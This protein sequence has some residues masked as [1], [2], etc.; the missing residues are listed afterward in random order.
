M[1]NFLTTFDEIQEEAVRLLSLRPCEIKKLDAEIVI[2][3]YCAFAKWV[4]SHI[5]E[6]ADKYNYPCYGFRIERI[7]KYL[8]YCSGKWITIDINSMFLSEI[9]LK[10]LILHEL[11]YVIH[12]NYEP[13]FWNQL[14]SN[15][16]A[17]NLLEEGNKDHIFE[18]R[19]NNYGVRLLYDNGNRVGVCFQ[20]KDALVRGIYVNIDGYN[21]THQQYIYKQ[22][23]R[24]GILWNRIMDKN[25]NRRLLDMSRLCDNGWHLPLWD[26]WNKYFER[27]GLFEL[28]VPMCDDIFRIKPFKKLRLRNRGPHN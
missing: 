6:Y 15:L 7:H 18:V 16:N 28:N 27:Y 12:Y 23:P 2:N 1:V 26:V 11:T 25:G 8:G 21:L 14:V 5:A 20:S 22:L 3:L 9:N 10:E 24:L 17:E 13:E 4:G 19:V